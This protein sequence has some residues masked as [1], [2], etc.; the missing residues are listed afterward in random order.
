MASLEGL[1]YRFK[2]DIV[3][4]MSSLIG[5]GKLKKISLKKDRHQWYKSFH[6]KKVLIVGSGPSLDKVDENYFAGF[7]V[8]IYINHAI[9]LSGLCN[10]EYFFS[11]DINA[12]KRIID[13]E[14]FEKLVDLGRNKS[15]IAPI[16]F[17]SVIS[18]DANFLN[19]FSLISASKPEY[20]KTTLIKTTLGLSYSRLVYWPVQPNIVELEAWFSA[21]DQVLH[22]P[23][24]ESTSALSCI[25]FASKYSPQS[26]ILIGC[27]FSKNR[28][29]LIINENPARDINPFEDARDK[30]YFLQS[31]LNKKNI[32]VENQSWSIK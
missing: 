26:V 32:I 9:K 11:T 10:D 22:F 20:I 8:I 14:Y 2:K 18:S 1:K 7:D 23:V 5:Y 30:F 13:K 12:T 29:E 17:N 31:F 3:L 16:H 21:S 15:I 24:I 19:N 4:P 28:S 6:D 25:L 27:D